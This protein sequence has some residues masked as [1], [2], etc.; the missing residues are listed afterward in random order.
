[1]VELLNFFDNENLKVESQL[2]RYIIYAH[3]KE[4]CVD[5]AAA[6]LFKSLSSIGFKKRQVLVGM[7]NDAVRIQAGTMQWYS[8]SISSETGLGDG[9]DAIG[10]FAKGLAKG[11]ITGTTAVRPIYSGCG[12]LMLEPTYKNILLE[13]V[14]DW[15]PEGIVLSGGAFLACDCSLEEQTLVNKNFANIVTLNAFHLSYRGNGVVAI[16][17]DVAREELYTVKLTDDVFHVDDFL[18]IA[19][20]G[21]LNFSLERSSKSIAGSIVNQEGAVLTFRG[22]GKIL[23]APLTVEFSKQMLP[24]KLE[25]SES[26]VSNT[27]SNILSKI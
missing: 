2:G 16:Q 5:E 6:S 4:L 13:N 7:N 9:V 27:V 26:K 22:T 11:F 25:A 17:S 15:G 3:Q 18:P 14:A 10:E 23:V 21:S 1:M 12:F 19:W 8:G 24:K 20:S